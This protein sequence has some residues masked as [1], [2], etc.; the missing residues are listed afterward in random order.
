MTIDSNTVVAVGQLI[1][2][3]LGL[4][5]L[6]G[7]VQ[8]SS[9]V[10]EVS[11]K[12][13]IV[14]LKTRLLQLELSEKEMELNMAKNNTTLFGQTGNNGMNGMLRSLQDRLERVETKLDTIL[15]KHE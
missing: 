6:S 2:Y 7:K 15:S 14:E 11:I 12:Q 3:I 8:G 13:D 4:V 10:N 1:I 5:W 9:G